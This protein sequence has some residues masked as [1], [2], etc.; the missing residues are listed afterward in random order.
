MTTQIKN[1]MREI[2]SFILFG[3]HK[4]NA[5]Q[6]YALRKQFREKGISIRIVKNN[7]AA[8]ALQDIHQKNLRNLLQRPTAIAYGGESPVD[9]AKNLFDWN[10]KAKVLDIKGGFLAGQILYK[11]DVEMLSCIPPKPVLLSMMAGAFN[12]PLSKMA[13]VLKAPLRELGCALNALAEKTEDKKE[14]V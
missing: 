7:L 5:H 13:T 6:A 8:V 2:D 14:S 4:L 12:S 1:E 9:V 3:F 10:K 11:K